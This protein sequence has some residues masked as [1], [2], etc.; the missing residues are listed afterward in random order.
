M[1]EIFYISRIL[2]GIKA[3]IIG[4]WNLKEKVREVNMETNL[5]EINNG[6][7]EE[8]THKHEKR[9]ANRISR[10]VKTYT[11]MKHGGEEETTVENTIRAGDRIKIPRTKATSEVL[12][13]IFLVLA[14]IAQKIE[15]TSNKM[16]DANEK[17]DETIAN[18][19]EKISQMNLKVDQTNEDFKK[20]IINMKEVISSIQAEKKRPEGK[21]D[22][23]P[24]Q[25]RRK[26][27]K[28]KAREA[29]SLKPESETIQKLSKQSDEEQIETTQEQLKGKVQ[30]IPEMDLKETK[31]N[32]YNN[33]A[34]EKERDTV[35]SDS[36]ERVEIIDGKLQLPIQI[37]CKNHQA[38]G[39]DGI[40]FYGREKNPM[41][42]FEHIEQQLKNYS[43]N[44]KLKLVEKFLGPNPKQWF[45]VQC[46]NLRTLNEFKIKF[47]EMY[48]NTFVQESLRNQIDTGK[49]NQSMKHSRTEYLYNFLSKAKYLEPQE[50]EGMLVRK[51]GKHYGAIFID[52]MMVQNI[53][54]VEQLTN[55]IQ[56]LEADKGWRNSYKSKKFHEQNKKE[57]NE[58]FWNNQRNSRQ[59]YE[60][61]NQI[62]NKSIDLPESN[63]PFKRNQREYFKRKENW[64][65]REDAT[66]DKQNGLPNR[67]H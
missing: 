25:Q 49:Y 8:K 23:E 45:N 14:I 48:W 65:E 57:D 61:A 62:Q 18:F 58:K 38:L 63:F 19:N 3:I 46:Q 55:L 24:V 27:N 53:Q 29:E 4:I 44:E 47:K 30:V 2:S 33:F 59:D 51:L 34:E 32:F 9:N 37:A 13:Q 17:L 31:I 22:H 60:Q 28:A 11:C 42:I 50:S 64:R 26:I 39:N 56:R 21:I 15:E 66:I 43:E 54:T 67:M 40:K 12:D 52:C 35:I 16:D 7:P 41:A 10:S 20:E 1:K 6:G 36:Q 5:K